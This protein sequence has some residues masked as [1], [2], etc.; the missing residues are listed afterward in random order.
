MANKLADFALDTDNELVAASAVASDALTVPLNYDYSQVA[1][2]HRAAIRRA[3]TDIK[4]REHRAAM[5]IV[6]IGRALKDVQ[7]RLDHGQFLPWLD[8]EFGWERRMAYNFMAVANKFAN[9]AN[10]ERFG[11][12][13]LYLLSGPNVPDEA[14]AEANRLVNQGER[15][16]H[17]TAK[18]IVDS[19]RPS[20]Q[21]G[22]HSLTVTEA[23]ALIW[24]VIERDHNGTPWE[25]IGWLTSREGGKPS[26]YKHALNPGVK[27]DFDTFGEAWRR[28]RAR[29][30]EMVA[31]D[32]SRQAEAERWEKPRATPPQPDE[33]RG[34]ADAELR[35][36]LEAL[37]AAVDAYVMLEEAYP[38]KIKDFGQVRLDIERHI[39]WLDVGA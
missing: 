15:V 38:G 39:G 27:M 32:E 29:L 6:E 35:T 19:Y 1:E 34:L 10:I 14:I 18:A 21:A 2:E 17:K 31:A 22:H 9:F 13:A 8:Q 28:V 5:D 12:S 3:A 30:N 4:R 7:D 36:V 26:S 33:S 23:Q 20:S 25:M 37:Y 24:R 16:T 11:L